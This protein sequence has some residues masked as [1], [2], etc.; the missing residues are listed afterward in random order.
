M[1]DG[2]QSE[3]FVSSLKADKSNLVWTVAALAMVVGSDAQAN[4]HTGELLTLP[5][6]QLTMPISISKGLKG[7]LS[8]VSQEQFQ[9]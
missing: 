2:M 7:R 9:V 3:Y 8:S 1:W 6:R 5:Y 4:T